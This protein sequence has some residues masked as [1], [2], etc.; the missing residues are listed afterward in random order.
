MKHVADKARI[1]ADLIVKGQW[2]CASKKLCRWLYWDTAALCLR[3][4]LSVPF[5]TRPAKIPLAI[6]PLQEADIPKLL[7]AKDALLSGD[8]AFHLRSSIALFRFGIGTCYVAST[9]DG[10]PC[11]LQWLIGAT[12]NEKLLKYYKGFH[13]P[14]APD[15]VLMEYGFTL[16]S[17]RGLGIMSYALAR[18]AEG[19]E[20]GVRWALT[21]VSRR[22]P[23]AMK[24][25]K[26][27][28]FSPFMLRRESWRFFRRRVSFTLLP[29]GTPYPFEARAASQSSEP[30]P[31]QT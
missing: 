7:G 25:C 20:L 10:R 17:F 19:K 16:E 9:L 29:E 28:G 12:E 2:A 1:V 31:S 14:L 18:I 27:A 30:A 4:D 23:A 6:R 26:R 24:G 3:R 21:Y 13:A 8:A 15:Q 11:F 5:E 22:N